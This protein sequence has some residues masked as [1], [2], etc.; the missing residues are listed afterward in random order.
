MC[1][2]RPA[3]NSAGYASFRIPSVRNTTATIT[4]I[5]IMGRLRRKMFLSSGRQRVAKVLDEFSFRFDA[6]AFVQIMGAAEELCSDKLMPSRLH[7]RIDESP[8]YKNRP[9]KFIAKLGLFNS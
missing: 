3:P 2:N 1:A 8:Q 7:G 6:N 9:A 4:R 5:K